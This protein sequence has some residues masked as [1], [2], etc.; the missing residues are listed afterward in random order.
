[1][2]GGNTTFSTYIVDIQ[3]ALVAGAPRTALLYGAA[4]LVGALAAAW[5]GMRI[6]DRLS[7]RLG[8][9]SARPRDSELIPAEPADAQGPGAA[10][11]IAGT[12]DAQGPGAAGLI[13][14]GEGDDIVGGAG[15]AS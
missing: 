10:G 11:L 2:L 9:A 1:V 4:T 7:T 12:A 14:A 8:A 6:G 15:R 13:A 5:A 3:R